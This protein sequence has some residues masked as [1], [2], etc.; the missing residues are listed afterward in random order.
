[1]ALIQDFRFALRTIRR[2]P[3]FALPSAITLGLGI[4]ATSAV[5]GGGVG[6][7]RQGSSL[8]TRDWL[9]MET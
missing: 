7:T 9:Q 3:G 5:Y 2:T 1:M 6:P 8:L 4:G